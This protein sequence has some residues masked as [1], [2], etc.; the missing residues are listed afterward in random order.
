RLATSSA[1]WSVPIET[2]KFG[3]TRYGRNE[4]RSASSWEKQRRPRS[5]TSSGIGRSVGRLDNQLK[6]DRDAQLRTCR[7][8]PRT[9]LRKTRRPIWT[10]TF[11]SH[12]GTGEACTACS[13]HPSV[14]RCFSGPGR[15]R[16]LINGWDG[17]YSSRLSFRGCSSSH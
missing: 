12:R 16:T 4:G 17:S 2:E 14:R 15:E 9:Y 10:R 3:C 13:S 6:C 5:R 8:I 7:S 11:V 1:S